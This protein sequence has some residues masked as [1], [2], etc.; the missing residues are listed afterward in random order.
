MEKQPSAEDVEALLPLHV[1][2][3]RTAKSS[4]LCTIEILRLFTDSSH[5]MTVSQL[6]DALELRL[7]HRPSETKV[8][9][10][11]HEIMANRPFGM[12]VTSAARGKA[13]GFRCTGS[14]L[15][16]QQVRLLLNM[17]QTCK[18]VTPSQ[19]HGLCESLH[20]IVSYH[21][22][23]AITE[24]VHADKR[25]AVDAADAFLAA[26][27][28]SEAIRLHR[29][30]SF[31]YV[32][33]DFDGE[34]KPV[35][36]A[37]CVRLSET[38]VA[39]V[40][41]FGN[42]YLESL[43]TD[44]RDE[45]K[46]VLRRLDKMRDPSVSSEAMEY[47]DLVADLR[48]SLERRVSETFDMWGDGMQRTV[49][50]RVERPYARYVYDR[51]GK[52]VRFRQ[53]SSDGSHAFTCVSVQLSPTFYRWIFGMGGGILI[54]KPQS[55]IWVQLFREDVGP[56]GW[57]RYDN[58]MEDYEAALSGFSKQMHAACTGYGWEVLQ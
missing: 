29:K 28:C 37:G 18:F 44:H 40:F 5:G 15:T 50:L 35:L 27:V 52:S 12:Q 45:P 1:G 55:E 22:Q 21:Q 8:L 33:R 54:A 6:R 57:K 25:E 30:V 34:E 7:G 43:T 11:L 41:S 2:E 26:D 10:D 9:D 14:L 38:P 56:S 13:D 53:E 23:D 3:T 39:L 48:A 19:R 32:E 51:F 49:F 16:D 46:R 20:E 4:L 42:Y 36:V 31:T 58:L 17:V 47:P 24:S